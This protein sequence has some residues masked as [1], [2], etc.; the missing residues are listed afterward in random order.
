MASCQGAGRNGVSIAPVAVDVGVV[1]G[2]LVEG[3]GPIV[4]EHDGIGGRVIRIMARDLG[5]ATPQGG[6]LFRRQSGI[7]G[8]PLL[9]RPAV[10]HDHRLAVQI[11]GT[12]VRSDVSTVAPDGA[13]LLAARRLPHVLPVADGFTGEQYPSIGGNHLAG[14]RRPV[15]DR[16]VTHGPEHRERDQ[17]HQA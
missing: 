10:K 13:D 9:P 12:P 15:A 4:V 8:D 2:Q 1:G 3:G 6:A 11:I 7:V 14:G 16:L 17:H 5:E